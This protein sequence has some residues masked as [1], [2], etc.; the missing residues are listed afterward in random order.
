MPAYS[1]VRFDFIL[2]AYV[3]SELADHF[4]RSL[5][6]SLQKS[7]QK[8]FCF[9]LPKMKSILSYQ[10]KRQQFLRWTE[11]VEV[12]AFKHSHIICRLE[13][14]HE[15]MLGAKCQRMAFPHSPGVAV[16]QFST[17]FVCSIILSCMYQ[18]TS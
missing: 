16:K 11:I 8:L 7:N 13:I 12:I 2:R 15:A 9:G 17:R 3:P 14:L 4:V 6:A 10:M 18:S 1:K 5:Q